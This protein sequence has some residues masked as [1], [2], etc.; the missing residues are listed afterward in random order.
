VR[1]L[2]EQDLGDDSSTGPFRILQRLPIDHLK[3]PQTRAPYV[4]QALVDPTTWTHRPIK[5]SC[6]YTARHLCNALSLPGP[7]PIQGGTEDEEARGH[8][9]ADEVEAFFQV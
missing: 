2:C 6:S 1:V 9:P 3:Q 5:L 7:M 8:M 4:D